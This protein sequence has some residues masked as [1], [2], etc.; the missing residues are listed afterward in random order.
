MEN[1]LESIRITRMRLSYDFEST[2]KLAST[3]ESIEDIE[4][5]TSLSKQIN[6]LARKATELEST[7]TSLGFRLERVKKQLALKR[8]QRDALEYKYRRLTGLEERRVELQKRIKAFQSALHRLDIKVEKLDN[9]LQRKMHLLQP[10]INEGFI[11]QSDFQ[12]NVTPSLSIT[13]SEFKSPTPLILSPS[14]AIG[15]RDSVLPAIGHS[16]VS[17]KHISS[18]GLESVFQYLKETLPIG[19]EWPNIFRRLPWPKE[20]TSDLV[21]SEIVDIRKNTRGLKEQAYRSFKVW[22]NVAGSLATKNNL[23]DVLVE[24]KLNRIAETVVKKR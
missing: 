11:L 13:G 6:D 23:V 21:E 14:P 19:R 16:V 3:G 9:I 8:Q 12:A 1:D 5:V 10:I 15:A 2:G 17:N 18:Q 7:V 24:C 22:E 20:I 4:T